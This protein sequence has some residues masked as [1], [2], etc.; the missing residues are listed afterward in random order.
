MAGLDRVFLDSIDAN[1]AVARIRRD[2]RTDF[3]LAPHYDAIFVKAADE[4]W[5]RT[6]ELL[7]SGK[8]NPELPLTVAVPK[9]RG[10][11]RPGSVLAPERYQD[12]KS[13]RL[14]SSH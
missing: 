1:V 5:A 2:V 11:T 9:P 3:I 10:F 8:Y 6:H 7:A 4:L 13:T 12:R 14:N